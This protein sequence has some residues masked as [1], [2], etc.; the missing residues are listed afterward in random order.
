[1]HAD[2]GIHLGSRHL[3]E[4]VD[5]VLRCVEQGGW[6][7]RPVERAGAP[8]DRTGTALSSIRAGGERVIVATRCRRDRLGENDP[9]VV[10][11]L[12]RGSNQLDDARISAL[13]KGIQCRGMRCDELSHVRVEGVV[14]EEVLSGRSQQR[15]LG[16][17]QCSV[18]GGDGIAVTRGPPASHPMTEC[19]PSQLIDRPGK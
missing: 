10:G 13:D 8:G 16:V 19:Q 15:D 3:D 18:E 9:D 14:G 11:Q 1:M 5:G 17:D 4:P 2:N 6:N 7:T 12:G